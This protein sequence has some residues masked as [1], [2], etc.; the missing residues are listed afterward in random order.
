LVFLGE[1]YTMQSSAKKTASG[2][3]KTQSG[4]SLIELLIVIAIILVITAIAVPNLLR[5]R[6]AANQASAVANLR[7]VTTAAVSYWV[8][9]GN[10]YPPN[11]ATLGG[12]GAA[13]TCAAALLIDNQIASAPSQKSGYQFVLN[14]D[15]GNVTLVPAGCPAPGFMGYLATSTPTVEGTTGIM[16]YC[17]SEPGVIHYDTTGA[18]AGSSA[19]CLALPSL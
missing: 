5:S 2:M 7:T 17:S 11:L 3:V 14:G 19:I 18:V 13:P 4:F 12:V 16:S 1:I 9:Y 6:Q 8:Q 15:Q 10:G